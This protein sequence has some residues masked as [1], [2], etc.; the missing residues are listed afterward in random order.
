MDADGRW[1]MENGLSLPMSEFIFLEHF[2]QLANCYIILKHAKLRAMAPGN[3]SQ[4]TPYACFVLW[5]F[6]QIEHVQI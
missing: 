3:A 6:I 4:T 1:K 5:C 2:S